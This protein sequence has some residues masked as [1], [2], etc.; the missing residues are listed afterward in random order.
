MP[1]GWEFF[2]CVTAFVLFYYLFGILWFLFLVGN[3]VISVRRVLLKHV[4][5]T[6]NFSQTLSFLMKKE[7]EYTVRVKSCFSFYFSKHKSFEH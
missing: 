1:L 6:W 2:H 7:E 5:S 4:S 3:A